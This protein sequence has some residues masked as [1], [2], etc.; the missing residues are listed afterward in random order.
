MSLVWVLL[1]SQ[2]FKLRNSTRSFFYICPTFR[3]NLPYAISGWE[4]TYWNA[5]LWYVCLIFSYK[6]IFMF[7]SSYEDTPGQNHTV[8]S[9]FWEPLSF[10]I[11]HQRDRPSLSRWPMASQFQVA[12]VCNSSLFFSYWPVLPILM[13]NNHVHAGSIEV[14]LSPRWWILSS[15]VSLKD[16]FNSCTAFVIVTLKN[17]SAT[18]P[19]TLLLRWRWNFLVEL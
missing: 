12:F 3:K 9:F 8:W 15:L 10:T 19:S 16:I 6:K 5:P 13:D 11:A 14:W 17:C 18:L 7:L 1:Q 4:F 2:Y